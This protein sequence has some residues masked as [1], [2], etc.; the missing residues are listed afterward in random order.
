MFASVAGCGS[1][2]NV[3]FQGRRNSHR[4]VNRREAGGLHQLLGGGDAPL[5]HEEPVHGI[6]NHRLAASCSA[7]SRH[8]FAP[9]SRREQ[10][11]GRGRGCDGADECDSSPS[12]PDALASSLLEGPVGQPSSPSQNK[13]RRRSGRHHTTSHA[14]C[15]F[16]TINSNHSAV[17]YDEC[18]NTLEVDQTC[19]DADELQSAGGGFSPVQGHFTPK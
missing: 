3:F 1:N 15:K 16:H 12:S 2:W 4:D 7:T 9:H 8:R 17:P 14:H 18:R 6:L 13:S 10:H 11:Q 19:V 5:G